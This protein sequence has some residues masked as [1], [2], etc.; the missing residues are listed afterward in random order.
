MRYIEQIKKKYAADIRLMNKLVVIDA[1]ADGAP[2]NA[3]VINSAG[4]LDVSFIPNAQSINEVYEIN[5]EGERV[6]EENLFRWIQ[7][8]DT[9]CFY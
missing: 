4:Y 9:Q 1:D 2:L 5:E 8:Y 6:S 7:I 3:Q